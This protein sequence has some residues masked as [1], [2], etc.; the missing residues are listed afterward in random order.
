[1]ESSYF[2]TLAAIHILFAKWGVVVRHTSISITNVNLKVTLF[3][4]IPSGLIQIT[5]FKDRIN[6]ERE[7]TYRSF[8]FSL[9]FIT[10]FITCYYHSTRLGD[11]TVP[12]IELESL[13]LCA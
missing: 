6:S 11:V 7:M 2:I 3:T 13:S 10:H 1:M 9:Q 8:A 12:A 4:F 5:N